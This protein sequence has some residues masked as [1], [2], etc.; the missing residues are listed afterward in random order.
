MSN[1]SSRSFG[2]Y[3]LDA[4][5]RAGRNAQVAA[6]AQIGQYRMH[7]F[8]GP[9]D[10][11]DRTGLYAFGATDA[12]GFTDENHAIGSV[13]AVQAVQRFRVSAQ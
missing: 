6:G 10:G 5:D 7:H 11:V 13:F 4:I 2:K 8:R 9:D 12:F 3:D 1:G